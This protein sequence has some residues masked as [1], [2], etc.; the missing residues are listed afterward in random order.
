MATNKSTALI[1]HGLLLFLLALSISSCKWLFGDDKKADPG[2]DVQVSELNWN[3][4]FTENTSTTERAATIQA[5]EDSVKKF[6]E[7]YPHVRPRFHV[8]F[9]PCDSSLYTIN[10]QLLNGA[11]QSVSAPPAP[12]P[13]PNGSG[14]YAHV[15]FL[16][17][18]MKID[19]L[20]PDT[21]S[22]THG[23]RVMVDSR[24]VNDSALLAIIDTG[25]DTTFFDPRF[26]KLMWRE[27]DGTTMYN[28]IPGQPTSQFLDDHPNKHGTT[29][30]ALALNNIGDS[31]QYPRIM[32]LK[33]LDKDKV[34]STFS[35]SCALSYAIQHRAQVI[36]ASLG[37]KGKPD[38]IL[39]WYL[40]KSDREKKAVVFV[41]AGN[42]SGGRNS[43]MYCSSTINPGNLLTAS[44][45]FYPALFSTELNNVIAVTGLSGSFKPCY[46]Q[47]YSR[48][49]I[50]LGVV[51]RVNC[52]M[53]KIPYYNQYYEGS[54]YATPV[55]AGLMM[56]CL[57]RNQVVMSSALTDWKSNYVKRGPST[58]TQGGQYIQPLH[59]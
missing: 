21:G 41:A 13:G 14:D 32:V 49:Y 51:N 35:V 22:V 38:P 25:I 28:F 30:T 27:G 1:N 31:S 7:K 33:A 16:A 57:L 4:L 24:A 8:F 20:E 15:Q 52:C 40:A 12:P 45:P 39:R 6:Y 23:A 59:E 5:I 44:N 43:G 29:V 10:I 19:E 48:E 2:A 17:D 56:G 26:R 42:A 3:V 18:N 34:G 9:C 54:S 47:N 58:Y 46:Y 53:Y 11:G 37:Y 36:N 50:T 55:A